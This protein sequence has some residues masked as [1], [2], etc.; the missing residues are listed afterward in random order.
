MSTGS[1]AA[2]ADVTGFGLR[3]VLLSTVMPQD[4]WEAFGG[5]A[6]RY[7]TAS[8]GCITVVLGSLGIPFSVILN[9]EA[10]VKTHSHV[11]ILYYNTS[12]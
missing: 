1:A 4:E 8:R 3:A 6:V 10:N 9:W 7:V 5:V 12:N 2:A 11:I